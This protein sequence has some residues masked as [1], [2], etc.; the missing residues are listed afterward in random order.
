MQSDWVLEWMWRTRYPK[1]LFSW[2][3]SQEEI[4]AYVRFQEAAEKEED[5]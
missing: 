3:A 1:F 2:K 5:F 4:W